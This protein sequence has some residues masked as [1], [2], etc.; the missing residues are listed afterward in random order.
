[1]RIEFDLHDPN[2]CDFCPCIRIFNIG[3]A[4]CCLDWYM[5]EYELHKGYAR[6][7]RPEHCKNE[8]DIKENEQGR[9]KAM[10]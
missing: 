2:Y 7:I 9:L 6:Y 3:Q 5:I 10:Q 4:Q 1:M 8:R